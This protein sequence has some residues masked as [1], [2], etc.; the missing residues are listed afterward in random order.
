[1]EFQKFPKIARLNRD[2]VIT[3]KIDG[4]NAQICV[5]E[6]M[7]ILAGSRTKWITPEDDNYGFA[8]WVMENKDE[9]VKKLG[10]GIHYGE[11]W[12]QGIQRKYNMD[13]KVFSLFNVHK[14]GNPEVRPSCCLVVPT[15]FEGAFITENITKTIEEL[16]VNG[17]QASK[18]FMKP[19]GVVIFHKHGSYLFK[20]TIENDDK[21]KSYG[22]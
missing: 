22:A 21:G 8:R 15:L 1:M 13:K 17:S 18:G 2:C 19:E 6:D 10:V 12:G 14:W 4:T 16:K 9:L 3:E 5:T 11:W 20:Q 7:E